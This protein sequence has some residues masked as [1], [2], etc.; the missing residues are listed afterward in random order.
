MDVYQAASKM[1]EESA[2][3]ADSI[4]VGS[5]GAVIMTVNAELRRRWRGRDGAF[6]AAV[7]SGWLP[8]SDVLVLQLASV[9]TCIDCRET[10]KPV[11]VN[12][13]KRT[14][15]T[16]W[17][18]ERPRRAPGRFSNTD[19]CVN[20]SV[21]RGGKSTGGDDS[22]TSR[23]SG[24]GT[25]RNG[26]TDSGSSTSRVPR[27]TIAAVVWTR[28]SPC[29]DLYRE[30]P[31]EARRV[32]FGSNFNQ[33]V[34]GIEWPHGLE[35]IDFGSKF[36]HPIAGATWPASL[37]KLSFVDASSFDQP[38]VGVTWPEGLKEI[39]FGANFNQNLSGKGTSTAV[40]E[41]EDEGDKVQW[42]STLERIT[43]RSYRRDLAGVSW[44]P[45]LRALTIDGGFDLTIDGINLPDG[46]EELDI[47]SDFNHPING[48]AFPTGLKVLTFGNRFNQAIDQTAFPAGLEK[49][50]FGL[51]FDQPLERVEL[52]A[53]LTHLALNSDVFNR[54]VEGVAWPEC[55]TELYFGDAFN[56]EVSSMAWPA[57]LVRLVFGD[58]FNKSVQGLG[59][60]SKGLQEVRFGHNFNQPVE[61]VVW[62]R[63]LKL[64][65]FGARFKQCLSGAAWPSGLEVLDLGD[66]HMKWG[67]GPKEGYESWSPRL[68]IISRK[69]L[70]SL[71]WQ[72][73]GRD[74]SNSSGRNSSNGRPSTITVDNCP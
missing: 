48:V 59:W 55:M 66:C 20:N 43:L 14:P 70:G 39:S 69:N 54:P 33:P 15:V 18:N 19:E 37:K 6:R 3:A 32:T 27:P 73:K 31:S 71:G 11:Q 63:S 42:P 25:S 16:L 5:A 28:A 52:P 4:S 40:D 22:G 50:T 9:A 56:Q 61:S 53:S 57:G 60:P 38:L 30:L 58:R 13:A 74:G 65:H 12:V 7:V 36:T 68:R 45:G 34:T 44:P 47:S 21:L 24:G 49:L 35:E 64:L 29:P 17:S 10:Q 46:L 67:Y 23:G 62:P 1:P 51:S 72:R 41:E 2:P 8:L 26:G